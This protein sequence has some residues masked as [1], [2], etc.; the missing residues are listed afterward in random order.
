M[1]LTFYAPCVQPALDRLDVGAMCVETATSTGLVLLLSCFL[2]SVYWHM[3]KRFFNM[4]SFPSFDHSCWSFP[5]LCFDII[6]SLL[7][8]N[9]P[10]GN[11]DVV[12]DNGSNYSAN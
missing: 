10:C 12:F 4:N 1:T 7:I 9:T 11:P 6:A 5:S 3:H 8:M 2:I